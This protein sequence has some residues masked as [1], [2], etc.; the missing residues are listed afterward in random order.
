MYLGNTNVK[1]EKQYVDNS[2]KTENL[3]FDV[4]W[5]ENHIQYILNIFQSEEDN[6][7]KLAGNIDFYPGETH[8]SV[9]PSELKAIEKIWHFADNNQI[10]IKNKNY[11][12]RNLQLVYN[13]QHIAVN[14]KISSNPF[15]N[16]F[17]S[18]QNFEMENLNPLFEKNFKGVINGYI[19][20]KNYFA[21]KDISSRLVLK[22]FEI[23]TFLVGDILATS[24]YENNNRRFKVNFNVTRKGMKTMDIGGYLLPY[25]QADQFD[26]S[27]KFTQSNL[28]IIEPFIEENVSQLKGNLDGDMTVEGRF[29]HPVV[30]G[31][32]FIS[33]GEFTFNYLNTHYHF[34]SKLVFDNDKITVNSFDVRDEFDNKG[35][36]SGN[37]SHNGFRELKFDFSGDMSNL[38]VLNTTLRDNKLYYGTAYATGKIRVNGQ[39]KNVNITASARSGKGTRIFIPLEG[40]TEVTQEDFITFVQPKDSLTS[41]DEN[42]A[43]QLSDNI[44][45]EGVSMNLDL[46][47]TTDAYCEIIFDLT[48]GDIIRGRGNGKLNLQID[49]KG[50]FYMFGEYEIEEGGYNFTLYNIINKEFQI[51]PKSKITWIGDPYG[52]ILDIKAIYKQMASLAP[53]LRVTDEDLKNNPELKR[54]YPADVILDIKGNL[55]SPEINFDIDINDYPKNVVVNGISLETQV[56]AFK[57]KLATDEQELKRQVFSLIILKNF[58]TE[59]AFNVGG[60]IGKS[61]S[62]FISNQI[63]YWISQFDEN[64]EVDVDLGALDAEAFNTFQLRL[65]YSFLGGRLRVTRD[66][67]FTDQ[68]SNANLASVLGDWSVDYLLTQDG[69]YRIKIYSKTN[70]NTLNPTLKSTSTTAGFSLMNTLSFDQLGDLF[71][72]TRKSALDKQ[73][74]LSNPSQKT[75]PVNDSIISEQ[76]IPPVQPLN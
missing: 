6:Y 42:K 30:K 23:N 59:D 47:L 9:Q 54:K 71:K 49:T 8:I 36:F 48:A 62:E 1:S 14:G 7:A 38:Q 25:S 45:L 10:I 3:L 70:Y 69:K 43:L 32:A 39:Q 21:D 65:S 55:K 58:S 24:N 19:D 28:N 75:E 29:K 76:H 26:L 15:E 44:N 35:A 60:S 12:F 63:S 22:Q 46:D 5:K 34:N 68:N 37:I 61:V 52:A 41:A 53:I 64:L 31:D 74:N 72:K 57:N 50:D 4:H 56:A 11:D 18:I 40:S 17:I 13:D 2:P 33:N 16:L 66:G 67:G 73:N 20:V 27:A 51:V